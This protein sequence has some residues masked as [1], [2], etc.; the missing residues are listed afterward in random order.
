MWERVFMGLEKI[1]QGQSGLLMYGFTPPRLGTEAHRM[2]ELNL[3]RKR[4]LS[5]L[6]LD[7]CV[8]YDVQDESARIAKARPFP[9]LPTMSAL[10]YAQ[11]S[12]AGFELGRVVYL[13][14][15]SMDRQGLEEKLNRLAG[16]QAVVLV[17]SP[18]ARSAR[19][20]ELLSAI[21]AASKHEVGLLTGAV[22]IPERHGLKGDEHLRVV[23]KSEAGASFFVS[24]CVYDVDR[25]KNYLSDYYY[26]CADTGRPCAYQVFTLTVCG[27]EQT[28]AFMEWLGISVPRWLM[29]DLQRSRDI[30]SQSL[31]RCVE[32]AGEIAAYCSLKKIPFGFN[33]ESLSNK[34]AEIEAA[35]ELATRV[36]HILDDF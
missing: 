26:H 18:S 24:Q 22:V 36:R 23:A 30:L 19:G 20:I 12:L 5:A 7:A 28:L 14:A 9:Y 6:P 25:L 33:I 3:A 11:G 31:E 16:G 10:D 1:R 4:R 17:G 15:T 8:V 13:P 34:K 2:A 27:S 21:E 35:G 32:M 29:N